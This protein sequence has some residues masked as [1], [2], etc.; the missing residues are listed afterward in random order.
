M[1]WHGGG[2]AGLGVGWRF[3]GGWMGQAGSFAQRATCGRVRG[4][5]LV[6]QQGCGHGLTIQDRS[7]W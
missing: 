1:V 2:H 7:K 6:G 3:I 4:G 5:L